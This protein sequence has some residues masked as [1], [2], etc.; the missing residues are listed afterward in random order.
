MKDSMET[1]KL[2]DAYCSFHEDGRPPN[3]ARDFMHFP[4]PHCLDLLYGKA[5]G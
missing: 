2:F 1:T 4:A 5:G 3:K